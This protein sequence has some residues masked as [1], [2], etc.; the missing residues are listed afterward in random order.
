MVEL[1]GNGTFQSFGMLETH[2]ISYPLFR[3]FLTLGII[4]RIIVLQTAKCIT[5]P[6]GMWQMHVLYE[7]FSN[8]LFE[9]F[10]KNGKVGVGD[11]PAR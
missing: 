5:L 3:V 1:V 8:M 10:K 11:S 4:V 7:L 2:L 6:F 9:I